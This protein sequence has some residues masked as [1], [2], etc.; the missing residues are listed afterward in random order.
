VGEGTGNSIIG[1]LL[2]R[3]WILFSLCIVTP[4]GFL[5]KF[6][7]RAGHRWFNDYGGGFLYEVF[8][9]L[10]VFLFIPYRKY[11]T[12]IALWVL[13]IT[14]I[15]ETLQLWHPPFLQQIRSTFLGAALIGTTFVWWDFPYYVLGCIIGWVLMRMLAGSTSLL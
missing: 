6:Y 5:F 1:F 15:L 7:A 13:I 10:V 9:C 8:W 14:C 12:Q 3:K 11:I 2:K 4:A